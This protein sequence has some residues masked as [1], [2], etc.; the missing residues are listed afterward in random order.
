VSVRYAEIKLKVPDNTA[1]T[2]SVALRRLGVDA[3][4]VVHARLVALPD[5]GSRDAAIERL[6]ADEALFNPNLHE[7][8]AL[9]VE[10]PRPGEIWIEEDGRDGLESWR[11]YGVDGEPLSR[12]ALAD[13]CERLLCN[14]AVETAELPE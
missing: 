3:E 14:P 8:R 2:A 11:L 1:F 12:R 4:H 10:H 9:D 7:I 13:A 6:R 5:S